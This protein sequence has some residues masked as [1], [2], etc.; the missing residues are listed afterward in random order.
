M[1]GEKDLSTVKKIGPTRLKIEEKLLHNASKWSNGQ[2]LVKNETKFRSN[3]L[4]NYM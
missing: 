2:I 4:C 3:C 1:R